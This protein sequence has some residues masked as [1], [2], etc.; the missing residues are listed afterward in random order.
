MCYR[1]RRLSKNNSNSLST[2]T[3]SSSL[4]SRDSLGYLYMAGSATGVVFLPTTAKLAL[5]DGSN[6]LTVAF[7]RAIIAVAILV[8]AALTVKQKLGLPKGLFWHS[9]AVGIGGAAFVYGMYGAILTINISL[10]LLILFLFPMF[11]AAWEHVSGATKLQSM[12]W[13]WG[14]V[15]VA[16]LALIVGV[17]FG[18]IS[19]LGIALA[20]LAMF[21][22]VVITL[23]NVRVVDRT[24]SLVA[25]LHMSIW[26]VLFFGAGLLVFGGY[27]LPQTT[28]GHVGLLGNGFFYCLSWVS[29]FAGARILGATRAAMITLMEPPLAA[30]FAW[31]IFGE[32]FTPIQWI[33]FAA[34]LGS[35]FLFE[36]AARRK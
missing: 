26:G 4:L 19:L 22:S 18:E 24:G 1:P 35:L 28:I 5:E 14:L 8:I 25:N 30:L 15:A 6:V 33:G 2:S 34:V 20:M 10:A 23:V 17:K 31:L 36:K 21:A 12:Q 16:G 32:T 11:V 27:V 29:F 3:S 13:V 9:L 7:V